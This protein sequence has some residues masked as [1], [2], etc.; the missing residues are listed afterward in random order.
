MEFSMVDT[1]QAAVIST[2]G[3]AIANIPKP[4]RFAIHKL[5]VSAERN[6][7]G[8]VKSRKDVRQANVLIQFYLDHRPE[9]LVE[10]FK[11]AM[12][13]GPG[14]KRRLMQG[15]ERL[16]VINGDAVAALRAQA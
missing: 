16:E 15:L 10:T 5:I 12:A 14:W 9:E 1:L 8:E 13:R 4:D 11:D 7:T 2:E 6:A 3:V